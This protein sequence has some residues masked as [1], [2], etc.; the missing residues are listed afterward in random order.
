MSDFVNSDIEVNAI[1]PAFAKKFGFVMQFTNIG[2]QII[3][4]T[5]FKTYDMVIM[6]FSMVDQDIKVKFFEKTSLVANVSLDIVFRMF[7]FTLSNANIDFLKKE[8]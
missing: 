3:D 4:G 1:H 5:T 7:F 8:F 6:A 2:A